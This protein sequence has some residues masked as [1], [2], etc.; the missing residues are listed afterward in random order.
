MRLN[1]NMLK[2]VSVEMVNL[3]SELL[4]SGGQIYEKFQ[5]PAASRIR[6]GKKRGEIKGDGSHGLT[7][8]TTSNFFTIF[9]SSAS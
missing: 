5:S 7:T 4:V 6:G 9:S 2:N 8:M 1:S 3:L